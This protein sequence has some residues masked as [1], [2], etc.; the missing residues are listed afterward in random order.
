[1]ALPDYFKADQGTL[2]QFMGS[3]GDAT[4][5]L[6][7]LANGSARASNSY[8]LGATGWDQLWACRLVLE[9]GSAPT[10]GEQC[11]GYLA[12][13]DDDTVWNAGISGSDAAWPSDGNEDEWAK[14]LGIPACWLT[15]TND[16]SGTTQISQWFPFRP[17]ARY[18]VAVVDNNSGVSLHTT[19]ANLRFEIIPSQYLIQD[20]A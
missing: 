13:S 1:M 15:C 18:V 14:Q 5:T 2:I 11:H 4:L 16:A 9:F 12:F 6:A 10:A 17:I 19:A 3:G 7:S 20:A 8:D